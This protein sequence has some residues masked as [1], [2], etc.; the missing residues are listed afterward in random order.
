MPQ[1]DSK[2][3]VHLLSQESDPSW[4]DLALISLHS[5]SLR[6]LTISSTS[7]TIR[8]ARVA[9]KGIRAARKPTSTKID[10]LGL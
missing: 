5:I 8:T 7:R 3:W 2:W 9:K 10:D 1:D 4:L 6:S